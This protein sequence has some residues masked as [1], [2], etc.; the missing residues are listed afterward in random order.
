MA[1]CAALL[2]EGLAGGRCGRNAQPERRETRRDCESRRKFE[3]HAHHYPSAGAASNV[4]EQMSRFLGP[5]RRVSPSKGYPCGFAGLFSRR[6]NPTIV[7]ESLEARLN[8]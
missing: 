3:I 2:I 6:D 5:L 8:A 7:P 1:G 4:E